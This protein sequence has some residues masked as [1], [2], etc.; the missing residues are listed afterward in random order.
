MGRAG[1]Y[2]RLS[3]PISTRKDSSCFSLSAI[4]VIVVVLDGGVLDY[5]VTSIRWTIRVGWCRGKKVG[6]WKSS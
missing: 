3:S 1:E 5:G 6:A 2:G 4:V